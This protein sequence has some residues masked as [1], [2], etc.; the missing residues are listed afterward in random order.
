MQSQPNG[1]HGAV[2]A[3]RQEAF[4]ALAASQDARRDGDHDTADRLECF[5]KLRG[6]DPPPPLVHWTDAPYTRALCGS[7][8]LAPGE[9]RDDGPVTCV[10][11]LD[12][13]GGTS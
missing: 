8:L 9:F 4:V 7:E 3:W 12:L 5:A 13:D 6:F 11:C 1:V 2:T 10:V